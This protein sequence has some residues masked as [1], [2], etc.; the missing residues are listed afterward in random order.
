MENQA[1]DKKFDLNCLVELL[2]S[3]SKSDIHSTIS[4]DNTDK[5]SN[6]TRNSDSSDSSDSNSDEES[7]T[8]VSEIIKKYNLT[9]FSNDPHNQQNQQNQQNKHSDPLNTTYHGG[10]L[11]HCHNTHNHNT[12]NHNTHNKPFNINLIKGDKG[13]RGPRGKTGPEGKRGK[14]G[15][16]GKDGKRGHRGKIGPSFIWKGEWSASVEYKINDVVYYKGSTYVAVNFSQN[17]T[18]DIDTF[19]WELM[20]YGEKGEQGIKGDKGDQGEKGDIGPIGPSGGEKGEKGDQGEKGDKGDRGDKGDQG[21][22]GVQGPI[23]EK[24][25][26]G[27]RG[28][29]GDKGDKGDQGVQGQIGP[30]GDKGDQ[31]QQNMVW[32]GLWNS[33]ITYQFGDVVYYFGSSYI[34]LTSNTDV[35]PTSNIGIVWDIIAL[36]GQTLLAYANYYGTTPADYPIS[37]SSNT[38]IDWPN[39]AIV[40][41]NIQRINSS[42]FNLGS[43]GVYQIQYN[44][45]I[46]TNAS[47]IIAIQ[48]PITNIMSEIPYTLNTKSA[49]DSFI[50]GTFL[51]QTNADN[52]ILT[53]R[54]PINPIN[55][56]PIVIELDDAIGQKQVTNCNLIITRFS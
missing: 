41:G 26:K 43:A 8:P 54:N 30:K 16:R 7:K 46:K 37:Y 32:K 45:C 35:I 56:E 12:H 52:S 51:I 23:G 10:N 25:D 31:G 21:V 24:G 40:Y 47:I 17:S 42:S 29:K 38:A 34:A 4:T 5:N 28:D 55:I 6:K 15:H 19:N 20:A 22:V 36:A 50:N 18:P 44:L 13:S 1:L 53:I 27:D 49:N 39:N 33:S 11:H 2:Q 3:D 48:D 14:R 9:V